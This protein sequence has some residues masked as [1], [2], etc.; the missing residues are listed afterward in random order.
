[1]PKMFK[2]FFQLIND[3]KEKKFEAVFLFSF[4]III[5]FIILKLRPPRTPNFLKYKNI[6]YT[7]FER[8]TVLLHY[9]PVYFSY[10]TKQHKIEPIKPAWA[11]KKPTL[12]NATRLT[13]LISTLLYDFIF[14]VNIVR[15]ELFFRPRI[16]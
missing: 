9:S 13:V 4:N 11:M 14:F 15:K 3:Y 12:T 16:L 5:L 2:M 10:C 6:S 8:S 7:V 1:M